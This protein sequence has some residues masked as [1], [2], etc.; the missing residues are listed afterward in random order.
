MKPGNGFRV[1]GSGFKL[2]GKFWCRAAAPGGSFSGA[3]FFMAVE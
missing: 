3:T 1:Q 2:P